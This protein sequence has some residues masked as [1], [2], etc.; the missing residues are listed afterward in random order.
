M[1]EMI[2]T[3]VFCNLKQNINITFLIEINENFLFFK[4]FALWE[5]L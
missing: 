3:F 4:H 1:F 5:Q 2:V